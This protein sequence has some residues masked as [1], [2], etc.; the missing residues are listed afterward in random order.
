MSTRGYFGIK[1][2]GEL[3]GAYNHWDSYPSGLGVDLART[4]TKIDKDERLEVLSDTFDYI[5]LI[6]EN[7]EP[8][9]E[10]IELCQKAN[11]VNL[12]VGNRSL[13]DW[14]C[15][16]RE[17]QGDLQIYIDKIIPY[18]V[19]GND[20]LEDTLFCE[21]AYIIDLDDNEFRVYSGA[22]E[23]FTTSLLNVNEDEIRDLDYVD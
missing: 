11:V 8:T 1:K 19:N 15:L 9:K 22:S 2:K 5:E 23:I 10:Q 4:I 7:T 17:T 20:F 3:K 14:Y 13:D 18:M 6:N 16:L 12:N 21:Y